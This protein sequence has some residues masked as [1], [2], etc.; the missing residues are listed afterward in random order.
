MYYGAVQPHP[1]GMIGVLL[2]APIGDLYVSPMSS[3]N[4]ITIESIAVVILAV[5]VV[6]YGQVLVHTH[7]SQQLESTPEVVTPTTTEVT[8]PVTAAERQA[9][10][11][12]LKTP[13]ETPVEAPAAV[14]TSAD[15][16]T[17]LQE[18]GAAITD[19]DRVG[20]LEQLR[21]QQ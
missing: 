12:L 7:F 17:T 10:Y 11:E 1:S 8:E 4:I 2:V 21:A 14:R 13:A 9:V 19:E 15:T 6:I 18:T 5:A 3:K 16:L 20:I